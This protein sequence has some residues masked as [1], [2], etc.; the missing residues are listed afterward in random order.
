MQTPTVGVVEDS[1]NE[2]SGPM[3][4]LGFHGADPFE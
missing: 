3:I 4:D 2:C 1:A